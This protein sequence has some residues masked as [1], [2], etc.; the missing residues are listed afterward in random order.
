MTMSENFSGNH[1]SIKRKEYNNKSLEDIHN[2]DV[3]SSEKIDLVRVSFLKKNDRNIKICSSLFRD[4]TPEHMIKIREHRPEFCLFVRELLTKHLLFGPP[5][6]FRFSKFRNTGPNITNLFENAFSNIAYLFRNT[7]PNMK[8]C[9]Q[10][11]WL[12][13]LKLPKYQLQNNN[14]RHERERKRQINMSEIYLSGHNR[15]RERESISESQSYTSCSWVWK[16]WGF[17]RSFLE[18]KFFLR[19]WG[20]TINYVECLRIILILFG[21]SKEIFSVSKIRN[22]DPKK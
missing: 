4:W 11:E 10:F 6:S 17:V 8:I 3:I 19:V 9:Q 16:G 5:R 7:S 13:F 21:G 1:N 15:M 20:C 18:Q 14:S 22:R 2:F 12:K